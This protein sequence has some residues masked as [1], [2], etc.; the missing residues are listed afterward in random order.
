[1]NSTLL[2]I[3]LVFV[4]VC[5]TAGYLVCLTIPDWDSHRLLATA[6]GFALGLLLVLTDVFL[7]G[8]SLRGLSAIS[9]GLGVG[10]LLSYLVSSSPLLETGDPQV[11]FLVRLSLFLAATYLCAVIAL[12]GKDEFNLV[13][14]YVRFVPHEV[15][16]PLVVVDT[17]ALIDGRIARICECGFVPGALLIPQFVL[18]ELQLV[19]DSVEPLRR[20]RGRRGLDTL[21]ALKRIKLIDLRIHESEAKRGEVDAKLVFLASSMK[22]KLLTTDQNLAKMA[23]FHGVVCLHPGELSRALQPEC[24]VGEMI[25]VDLIKPGKEEGQAVGYMSDGSMV[26][27]NDAKGAIGKRASA[28]IISVM[29]SGNGRLIFARNLGRE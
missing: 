29:P 19:A 5:A 26:V 24:A 7:K 10:T 20:A 23:E 25:E 11:I 2:P 4:F 21:G 27:V 12:R 16:V 6:F 13:I 22:A 9:F 18:R 28:E 8:F 1:M 3:R 14:P 15:D 17:S